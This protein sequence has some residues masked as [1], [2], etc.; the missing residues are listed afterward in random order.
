MKS[1][2][3]SISKMKKPTKRGYRQVM[4][5]VHTWFGLLLGWLLFLVFSMGTVSYFNEEITRWMQPE[6]LIPVSDSDSSRQLDKPIESTQVLLS[7]IQSLRQHHNQADSWYVEPPTERVPT[8]YFYYEEGDD[9][10]IGS[11]DAN[12]N[13]LTNGRETEGG[14]FFYRMHF[15][16]HYIPTIWARLIIGFAAMMML[17]A[18]ISGI[19]VHKKI[20]TDMFTFRSG[21]GQRSWLDA[22]NIFSVLPLP[23]HLMITITGIITLASTYMPWGEKVAQLTDATLFAPFYSYRPAITAEDDV[24]LTAKNMVDIKPLIDDAQANWQLVNPKYTVS[25][26]RINNP[27]TNHAKVMINGQTPHQISGIQ[28]YRSYDGTTGKLQEQSVPPPLAMQVN[29]TMIGLHAGRFSDIW[30]RWLYFIMGLSGSAM[31]ATGLVLWTAKRRRQ[32]DN[33][34]K[35]HIGFM[36]VE[37]LN[38]AAIAGLPLAMTSYL[39]FNRLLPL[40]TISRS[41]KEI[42]GFFIVWLASF[43]MTLL[44]PSAKAWRVLVSLLAF[45]L[46]ALPIVNMFT[47]TRGLIS[48]LQVGDW[49][50]VSFDAFFIISGLLSFYLAY[51]LFKRTSVPQNTKHKK[52]AT[53]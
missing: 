14:N 5:D 16:L 46:L 52:A 50:F 2:V 53:S 8:A 26:I 40:E 4:A 27:D 20:F 51:Y 22:H 44:L 7:A 45:S 19:I 35:P 3:R 33:P 30:L 48:S 38:I 37:K 31:I 36:L 10:T 23:F 21:K 42:A 47:T 11:Y 15:D 34:G 17:I 43:I 24:K 12:T 18:L 28:V 9:Y 32:L 13:T 6:L 1:D 41:D 29:E 49:L 25:S 39:W